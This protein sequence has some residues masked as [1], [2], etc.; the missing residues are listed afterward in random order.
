ME[1]LDRQLAPARLVHVRD[2]EESDPLVAELDVPSRSVDHAREERR[3]QDRELDG[4][5]FPQT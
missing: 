5:R 1:P 2:L 4:D 3:A